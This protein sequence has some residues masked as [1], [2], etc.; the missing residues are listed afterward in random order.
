MGTRWLTK[1]LWLVAAIQAVV[2]VAIVGLVLWA[3]RKQPSA[4]ETRQAPDAAQPTTADEPDFDL[5]VPPD[6]WRWKQMSGSDGLLSGPESRYILVAEPMA[7]SNRR[8][9]PPFMCTATVKKTT[10]RGRRLLLKYA[11]QYPEYRTC[12]GDPNQMLDVPPLP[13]NATWEEQ[14]SHLMRKLDAWKWESTLMTVYLQAIG[15][16][17][18]DPDQAGFVQIA[19]QRLASKQERSGPSRS[20]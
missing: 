16:L 4:V 12:L 2:A 10:L 18:V 8:K 20:R 13:A 6:G 9:V 11:E 14:W 1:H 5:P 3:S 19:R 15:I 7:L 17:P